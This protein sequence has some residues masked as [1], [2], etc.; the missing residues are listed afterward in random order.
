[1]IV[2]DVFGSRDCPACQALLLHEDGLKAMYRAQG[3]TFQFMQIDT[4]DCDYDPKSKS[5]QA[6]W[7]RARNA[8]VALVADGIEPGGDHQ[9]PLIVARTAD[10]LQEYTW[11]CCHRLKPACSSGG[12]AS[13]C[14]N[15]SCIVGRVD[16]HSLEQMIDELIAQQ[17]QVVRAN[18]GGTTR[19]YRL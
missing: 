5:S 6:K 12:D 7:A 8:Q 16:L 14:T 1:M 4:P 15:G 19:D 2:I 18:L 10:P 11:D 13:E 17:N 9:L 3:V